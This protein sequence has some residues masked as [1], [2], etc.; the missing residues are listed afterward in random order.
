[1]WVDGWV[2]MCVA[3]AVLKLWLCFVLQN[4]YEMGWWV[5]LALSAFLSRQ[6][7]KEKNIPKAY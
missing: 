1:M 6:D 3:I 2:P 7:K 5:P 4:E